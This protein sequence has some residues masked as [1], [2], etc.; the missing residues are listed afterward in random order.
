M[1]NYYIKKIIKYFKYQVKKMEELNKIGFLDYDI[2]GHCNDMIVF[3][4][5]LI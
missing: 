1:I 5:T 4:I 2:F 3:L